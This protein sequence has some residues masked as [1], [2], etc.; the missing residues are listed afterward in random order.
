MFDQSLIEVDGLMLPP[1]VHLPAGDTPYN[2][3]M[4]FNMSSIKDIW[5]EFKA[6]GALPGDDTEDSA[7]TADE[8]AT[9]TELCILLESIVPDGIS[10]SDKRQSTFCANFNDVLLNFSAAHGIAVQLPSFEVRTSAN[11]HLPV[12]WTEVSMGSFLDGRTSGEGEVLSC[13]GESLISSELSSRLSAV[14]AQ[15]LR[16]DP[17]VSSSIERGNAHLSTEMQQHVPEELRVATEGL[18]KLIGDPAFMVNFP[19]DG[20]AFLERAWEGFNS[21]QEQRR[22]I[23]K[24]KESDY[25]KEVQCGNLR[26]LQT[27]KIQKVQTTLRGLLPPDGTISI[28]PSQTLCS[29][30]NK[31]ALIFSALESTDGKCLLL[32]MDKSW[33]GDYVERQDRAVWDYSFLSSQGAASRETSQAPSKISGRTARTCTAATDSGSSSMDCSE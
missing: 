29:A 24:H 27:L 23:N 19:S 17:S 1:T 15:P 26:Y 6:A 3:P 11:S 12:T 14:R 18:Q 8:L 4:W 22:R 2:F 28:G 10:I 16:E 32:L 5:Q 20:A 31:F 21:L 13:S 33:Q 25:W 9:L 30:Y 7:R